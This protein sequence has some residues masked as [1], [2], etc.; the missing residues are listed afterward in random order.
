MWCN[1]TTK[2]GIVLLSTKNTFLCLTFDLT[3]SDFEIRLDE[4]HYW[5]FL[6]IIENG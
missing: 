3:F 5:S 4:Y 1:K 2:N 6:I